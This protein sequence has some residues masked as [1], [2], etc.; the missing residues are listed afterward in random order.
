MLYITSQVRLSWLGSRRRIGLISGKLLLLI[1]CG[2]IR[3]V[4]VG[5]GAPFLIFHSRQWLMAVQ[6][7]LLKAGQHKRKHKGS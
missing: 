4:P 2:V 3:K 1:S 5:Q 7:E 6:K